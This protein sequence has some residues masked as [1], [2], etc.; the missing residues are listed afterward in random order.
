[1]YFRQD[2]QNSFRNSSQNGDKQMKCFMRHQKL[3]FK[4][5]DN[6]TISRKLIKE[7]KTI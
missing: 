7:I 2:S 6:V 1:M 3:L 5:S 4:T